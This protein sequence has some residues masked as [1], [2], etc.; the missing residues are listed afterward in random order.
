VIIITIRYKI[1]TYPSKFGGYHSK[2]KENGIITAYIT[3][4]WNQCQDFDNFVSDFIY[5][6]ILERICLERGFQKIRMKNRC[7][8]CKM[9]K[10]ANEMMRD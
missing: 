8:P 7:K 10:Y 4:I 9:E 2:N 6:N 3:R 5:I 1:S